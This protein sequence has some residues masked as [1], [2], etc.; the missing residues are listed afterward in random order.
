MSRD[1]QSLLGGD[2]FRSTIA[3]QSHPSSDTFRSF[4]PG[5]RHSRR[6]PR[7]LQLNLDS[8]RVK[9]RG[10]DGGQADYTN[11]MTSSDFRWGHGGLIAPHKKGLAGFFSS[12]LSCQLKGR[13]ISAQI[14]AELGPQRRRVGL[15]HD[16]LKFVVTRGSSHALRVSDVIA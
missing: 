11:Q 13:K 15:M 3:E 1:S 14:T 5:V 8:V 16:P 4:N 7:G 12:Q 6:C 10:L 9:H 2:T